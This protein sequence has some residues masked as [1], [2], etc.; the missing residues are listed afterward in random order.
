MMI[1]AQYFKWYNG[2]CTVVSYSYKTKV[3]KLIA[4]DGEYPHITELQCEDK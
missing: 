2:S 3:L 1:N 4:I